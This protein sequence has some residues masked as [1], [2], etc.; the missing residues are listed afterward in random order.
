MSDKAYFDVAVVGGG[1]VGLVLARLLSSGAAEQGCHVRIAVIEAEA[2]DTRTRDSELDLRVSA[3]S[4]AAQTLLVAAGCWE[5]LPPQAVSPYQKMCV[6]QGNYTKDARQILFDAAELGVPELGYIVENRAVRASLWDQLM[7]TDG[8]ELVTGTRLTG[9]TPSTAGNGWELSTE[10]ETLHARLL[11]GAD[12]ARSWVRQ[13]L[14]IAYR[15]R[16]YGQNALVAHIASER[17]HDATAWQK[18]LPGGPAAL[19]PLAD[20]RSSLVWSHP[21]EQTEELLAMNDQAFAARL[22]S[23]FEYVLGELWCTTQRASFP[24]ARGHAACYTAERAVLIGDAAHR[25]HPLAGQGAN[26]GLLDARVL[27]AALLEHLRIPYADPGDALV[28]RR[29]ERSRKADNLAT[30]S[31]M[32]GLDQLFRSPLADVGGMGMGAVNQL[33]F[34]KTAL[35]RHAM[36]LQA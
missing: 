14:S 1:M 35:A 19:L 13:Q 33:G 16:S 12:G 20:G 11:V 30:M 2:P 34:L 21:A 24:L 29:Y 22:S 10:Q 17:P 18:F 28:L 32:D 31:A 4:P 27:A 7:Q 36:G 6:W 3:L 23:E 15:E 9:A 8:C 26:L 25:I 5:Q